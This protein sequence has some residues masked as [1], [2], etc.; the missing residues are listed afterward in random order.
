MTS[1]INDDITPND[2]QLQQLLQRVLPVN[3]RSDLAA[4]II[5]KA[6]PHYY[7]LK[8]ESSLLE[9]IMRSFIFPKPAYAFACSMLI[10]LLLGWQTSEMTELPMMVADIPAVSIEEDLSSLFL[11][12]VNYY[13]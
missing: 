13:E 12:E 8:K 4:R 5:A 2:D 3:S 6:D 1:N 10:G 7:R 9:Q 11:A